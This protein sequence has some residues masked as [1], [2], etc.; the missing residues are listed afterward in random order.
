MSLL[1]SQL[2]VRH[3]AGMHTKRSVVETGLEGIC[4]LVKQHK[5]VSATPMVLVFSPA[6]ETSSG[7]QGEFDSLSTLGMNLRPASFPWNYKS[8]WV[9]K[10]KKGKSKTRK[11][12]DNINYLCN[13]MST[14][15]NI[16]WNTSK[17]VIYEKLPRLWGLRKASR[18]CLGAI[19][20]CMY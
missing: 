14:K 9:P 12:N 11:E 10:F 15:C 19:L 2:H 20:M 7:C 6:T 13:W 3:H 4:R 5:K 8:V 18:W 1:N 17:L 16:M